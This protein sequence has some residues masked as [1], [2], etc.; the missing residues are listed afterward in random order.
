MIDPQDPEA[1]RTAVLDWDELADPEHAEMLDLYRTLILLR[2]EHPDL[3]DPDLVAVAVDYDEA[4]GWVVVH[5]GSLRVAVNLAPTE[6]DVPMP[7]GE[8]LLRTG[9]AAANADGLRMAPQTA[10]IVRPA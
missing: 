5:R 2:R 10:A 7:A 8:I 1:Y 9:P 3:A 4:A 6:Q